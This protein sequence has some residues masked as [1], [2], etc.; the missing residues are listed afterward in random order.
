MGKTSGSRATMRQSPFETHILGVLLAC[1]VA[2]S[3]SPLDL[4][5]NLKPPAPSNRIDGIG[6]IKSSLAYTKNLSF[7][8]VLPLR[9]GSRT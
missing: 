2:R 6:D 9:L 4:P 3:L 7:V 8:R 1:V 5:T